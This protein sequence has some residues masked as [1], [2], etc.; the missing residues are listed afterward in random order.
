[1]KY[2]TSGCTR[3]YRRI[4]DKRK[5]AGP[6]AHQQP[7]TNNSRQINTHINIIQINSNQYSISNQYHSI[8]IH[9]NQIKSNQFKFIQI[10]SNQIKF[11]QIKSIQINSN[12]FKSNQINSN[13]INQAKQS[14]AKQCLLTS[15]QKSCQRC[16][17]MPF[18][19]PPPSPLLSPSA[20]RDSL[21]V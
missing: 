15:R 5:L 3:K 7:T 12:S 21:I 18:D 19:S 17:R 2:V 13:Q 4:S 9:S 10:K 20:V 11:I 16:R 6:L 14:K 8:Q 1:M